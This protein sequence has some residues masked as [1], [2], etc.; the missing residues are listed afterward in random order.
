VTEEREEGARSELQGA[1]Y[2]ADQPQIGRD[3]KFPMMSDLWQPMMSTPMTLTRIHF[4]LQLS[5]YK[6]TLINK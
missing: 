2:D 1:C 4:S 3:A 6:P 5:N